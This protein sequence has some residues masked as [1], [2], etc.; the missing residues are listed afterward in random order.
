LPPLKEFIL[1][2]GGQAAAAC[3]LARSIVRRA[4][5]GRDRTR[6]A[7][8]SRSFQF[9][10]G[11]VGSSSKIFRIITAVR[12]RAGHTTRSCPDRPGRLG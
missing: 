6:G 12:K 7:L 5:P 8:E 9:V 2:G 1:P 10:G 4:E 3:H 11:A